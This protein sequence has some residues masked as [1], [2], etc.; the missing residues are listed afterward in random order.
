[1]DS[2]DKRDEEDWE[3]T[4]K[5]KQRSRKHV[6][7][8]EAE[9][10]VDGEASDGSGRRKRSIKGD[11][12]DYESR[13]KAAKKRL[14]ENT[15]EKLSSFYEDGELDGGEKGRNVHRVKEDFRLSEK[16]ESGRE[17]RELREKS[18]GSSEQKSSRRKWDEVDTVSVKKV[19]DS[20]SEKSD[21]KSSKVSDG[22]RSE[23][24]ERSGSAR[25]EHAESKVSGSDSKVVKS[26]GKDDRRSDS[27]RSKSKGKLETPDERVEKPR[28]HRT[29]TG[30]DVAETG[31]KSGNADEEGNARVRDKTVKE[32][33]SSTRSRTPEKS[34]K[35]HQDSEGSEM[36]YEKSGSFK[37]KELESDSYKDDRS[38]GKDETWSDRR[39]DRESSKDN[40]KRRQQ[41]NTDRDSKNEDG[42]FDHGREWELPRHGYDRMDNERPHGRLGGRKDVLRGEAV[43]TTTKFGI[44]NENYDVIEIQPKFV[45]YGKTD[46]VSNL[47]KRTEANQQYNSKSGG[48]H[49]ERSHHPDERARKSDLSGSGTPGEDQ[50]ERY[51]D[52][53]YDLYGGRGRGQKSVA[54]NRS[55]GGSQSQYGN[56]DS[57]SFNR[58]GPQGIK[59]N[60]VGRG[61][62]IRPPGR[63][64]QQVGMP[65]PMMGSPY[66]PLGMPPPGP[67][68]TLTHG[69][70]PGPPM[71]P[72]VFMS[73]FNPAVWPGPRGVDMNIMGV[74]PAV[75]PVPQ[76]PRF[77]TANMGNPPNSAM[78]YNQ[79][80][81]GRGI[82]PSISSPGFNHT[83]PMGRGAPPDKTQGGW[84][85]PKSSGTM[86]K[87]PSRGEQNDYSQ[88][89]VDTGMR[90]QNFIRELEL[91][92][93]VEDY[94]KLRELI[95]KKDE[96]VEKSA[97]T[98][99]YYKCNLKDFELAPE[100]FGTKFDVILVDPPWEEYA[101]RAP[102]VA[103]HTE[104]WTF[105][106][107]M[108][109][110]IEVSI[111]IFSQH[112]I[113]LVLLYF[114]LD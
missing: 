42:A 35:R 92:N 40:W 82:P 93:V 73:P 22:K 37:R 45:D 28:R 17:L 75:S 66:G 97:S 56:P 5:R 2:V 23:S 19:Q 87:A 34:G 15:L 14:E 25:N 94:P 4:D 72:G 79:S 105:E 96:I 61:G 27:E 69:M 113:F 76:G 57:G 53:D 81:H 30:F 29:P 38:K 112:F 95:Q 59:G 9:G 104:C 71:S 77:N 55:T 110:K 99:M 54:T 86:G 107:I 11:G 62:R 64:N 80:G 26:G 47:S 18:R 16:S 13:S 50:K 6:N 91:T 106:E 78:Y 32:T 48:N 74:P 44:S 12:D 20:V 31:D 108:N 85:P 39:K 1:M 33:G 65:L 46:S 49:E 8:D 98:P 41:G 89:F 109:L 51:A 7:G 60:R 21:L 102:G 90:P 84:A 88:N 36:D 111:I 68:Q 114:E 58:G 63:D 10:E 101:H 103:E 100:F 3:F 52:D 67:M 83:G 43:K 24:R 70:S